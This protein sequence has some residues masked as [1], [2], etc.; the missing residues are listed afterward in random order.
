MT[1]IEREFDLHAAVHFNGKFIINYYSMICSMS[2]ETDC[3]QE[4]NIAMDRIKCLLDECLS[5]CVFIHESEKKSIEKYMAAGMKVCTLPEEPYDQITALM[6]FHKLNAITEGRIEIS[7]ISLDSVIGDNVRFIYDIE[8]ADDHP[9]KTGWWNEASPSITTTAAANK[10]DK[11]VKL[12]KHTG[13]SIHD[14]DWKQEIVQTSE[15][16]FSQDLDK[17]QP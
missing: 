16:I 13:W 6:L 4:Q 7:A 1:S 14:L 12:V 5:N 2:V 11:I 15:I 3:I 10:K 17:G 8:N 9:Y